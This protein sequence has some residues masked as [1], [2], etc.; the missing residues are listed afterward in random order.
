L[1]VWFAVEFIRWDR[2]IGVVVKRPGLDDLWRGPCYLRPEATSFLMRLIN[3]WTKTPEIRQQINPTHS[4]NA[5]FL[6]PPRPTTRMLRR[7]IT[8]VR[9]LFSFIGVFSFQP[10]RQLLVDSLPS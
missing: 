8:V 6:M 5:F 4:Q 1:P 2:E 7:L 10:V 9:K 3:S